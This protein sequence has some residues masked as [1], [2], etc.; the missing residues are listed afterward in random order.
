[1]NAPPPRVL[2]LGSGT[3]SN[4]EA[5][6]EKAGGRYELIAVGSDKPDAKILERAERRGIRHFT[7]IPAD[8]PDRRAHDV[9]LAAAIRACRPD[10]VALAGYMRLLG[11]ETLAAAPGRILN[12][13]P[14]L[15]PAF[16]GLNTHRRA[17]EATVREHGSTVHFVTAALDAG[18]AILQARLA[19]KADDTPE[20]LETRV[21]AM[22]HTIY[23]QA[24]GW[25]AAGR[26]AMHA[27]QTWLDGQPLAEPITLDEH[28]L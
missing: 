12:I 3:G 8:Y 11:P 10:W 2:V 25:C 22:E 20:T 13:H 19:I 28:D 4:F 21:K 26:V 5:L 27:G 23:P 17:L 7:V 1:V 6:A 14:A 16:T 24:L 18:P 15:L 9:A